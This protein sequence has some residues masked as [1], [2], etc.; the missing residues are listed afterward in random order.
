[1][2]LL[3]L[4]QVADI[5]SDVLQTRIEHVSL[6]PPAFEEK[7]LEYGMSDEMA[8]YMTKL[9]Q[10]VSQSV[11]EEVTDNVQ[12]VS[13]SQPQTFRKFVKENRSKWQ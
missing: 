12:S 10:M 13:G 5:L 2:R 9:D 7:L 3:T 6:G 1:M 11:G 8:N 4:V